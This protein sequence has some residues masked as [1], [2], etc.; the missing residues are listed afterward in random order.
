M[1]IKTKA[2]LLGVVVVI[3]VIVIGIYFVNSLFVPAS[4]ESKLVYFQVES[5]QGVKQISKNLKE[6]GLIKTFFGDK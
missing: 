3:I 1:S 6:K 2:K 5:G 4:S